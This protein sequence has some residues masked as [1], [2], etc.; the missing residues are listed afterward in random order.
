MSLAS[1]IGGAAGTQSRVVALDLLQAVLR[2]HRP[3]DQAIAEHRGLAELPV[4][5]RAFARALVATTLR[6]LGTIDSLLA[7]LI[8]RPLPARAATVSDLL[9]L[10]VCQLLFLRTAAHAAVDSTVALVGRRG[11]AGLKGL[12]NAVLRRVARDGEALLG[13]VED[14]AID[15]PEW[16]FLSWVA[17]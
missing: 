14:A 3:L 13:Q 8:E 9:R 4:R 15:M 5:D 6:R 10:G 12:S 1:D 16:L 2:R 7:R 17:A 11:D